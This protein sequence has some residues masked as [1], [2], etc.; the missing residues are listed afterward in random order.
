MWTR[1][2]TLATVVA[3]VLLLGA[4]SASADTI[5]FRNG[6]E[7]TGVIQKVESGLVFVQVG[8]DDQV[9]NILEIESMDFNT[10]HLVAGTSNLPVEH[11]LNNV[12]SQEV[13][14]N[15]EEL[16][17]TEAEVR[18]MLIN[19]RNYWR[20]NQP[21]PAKELTGWEIEKEEFRKPLS[22]YQELLNDLYFHFLA[23]V[24]GYNTIAAEA[25]DVYV[26]VKGIRK[27]SALIPKDMKQLP[28]RKYVPGSW[29]D[30]IFFDGYN[31]G[32]EDAYQKFGVNKSSN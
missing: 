29:Y 21:I 32:Y 13:V 24:D 26:G 15:F 16:E 20:A 17:R 18:S 27:G 14:R 7:L 12:E 8:N 31:Q 22:R 10:P 9:F 6:T 30:T 19:I 1:N 3:V 23:R 28:L 4:T 2:I 11:F 5:K 25:S